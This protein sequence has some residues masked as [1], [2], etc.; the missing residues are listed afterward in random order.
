MTLSINIERLDY[1]LSLYGLS[2]E[3]L[4]GRISVGRKNPIDESEIFADEI[5]LSHLKKIDKLFEKGINYYL[6]PSD[7]PRNKEASVFFRKTQFNSKLNFGSHKVVNQFETFSNR[8]QGLASLSEIEIKRL[9][10]L[11]T[12]AQDPQLV[13][14]EIRDAVYPQFSRDPKNFLK[15]FIDNLS[16]KN[17]FVF[18][19]VETHN[20]T[21]KANID[22]FFIKPNVIVLKRQKY[23]KREIFS[24]AHELGHYL[25]NEEEVEEI[26]P[27]GSNQSANSNKVETWC[28]EFAFNLLAGGYGKVIDELSNA[29]ARND[30]HHKFVNQISQKTH[31]S[32]LAIYTR[33]LMNDKISNA[34]YPHIRKDIKVHI[35]EA[36]EKERS[37][38]P[39]HFGVAKAINAPL[40]VSTVQAAYHNGLINEYEVSKALNIKP[41]KLENFLQ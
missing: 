14:M 24:L 23:L 35:K 15:N 37:K 6:D 5:K 11:Y 18:E 10:R 34:S 17:I 7:P 41:E 9:F 12:I 19:F 31:L 16:A 30:Y 3:E 8:L 1:L 25:L 29:T 20:K 27:E 38:S 40:T 32:T 33:L 28:N 36:E 26:K 22:G 13:A 4:C 21:D 2:R 39:E